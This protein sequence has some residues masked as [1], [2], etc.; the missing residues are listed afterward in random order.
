VIV[1]EV[2]KIRFRYG[3]GREEVPSS[4]SVIKCAC[5]CVCVCVSSTLVRFNETRAMMI[6]FKSSSASAAA[7]A[8]VSLRRTPCKG[9]RTRIIVR[10]RRSEENDD[11]DDFEISSEIDRVYVRRDRAEYAERE[12]VEFNDPPRD[13]GEDTVVVGTLFEGEQKAREENDYERWERETPREQRR[14]FERL[15]EV[16]AK[17][18]ATKKNDFKIGEKEIDEKFLSN[19]MLYLFKNDDKNLPAHLF[20]TKVKNELSL[21]AYKALLV[22]CGRANKWA[23]CE[24]IIDFV[25]NENKFKNN[26]NNNSNNSKS[27]DDDSVITANWFVAI[28]EARMNEKEYERAAECFEKMFEFKCQPSGATIELFARFTDFEFLFDDELKERTKDIYEWL[29]ET[30]AGKALWPTYFGELGVDNLPGKNSQ[31]GGGI[32]KT[33]KVAMETQDLDLSG[34]IEKLQQKLSDFY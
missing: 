1:S 4:E 9:E 16:G 10:G 26:S 6:A 23:L 17:G 25:K 11:D 21:D 12:N 18:N 2:L 8:L 28:I 31:N 5:V 14:K 13:G 20:L 27:N 7:A 19:V 15:G 32:T 30:D 33:I 34:D 24:Q 29:V 22:G 3:S